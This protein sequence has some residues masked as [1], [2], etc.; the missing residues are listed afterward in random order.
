VNPDRDIPPDKLNDARLHINHADLVLTICAY[1]PEEPDAP[2]TM[3]TSCT[4]E[5]TVPDF[6]LAGMGEMLI[7]YGQDMI[8]EAQRRMTA[9]SN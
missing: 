5:V 9:R 1:P 3:T 7:E 8:T 2:L 6:I 4:V